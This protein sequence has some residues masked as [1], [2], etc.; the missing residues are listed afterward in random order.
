MELIFVYNAKHGWFHDLTGSIHKVVSPSTYPCDLCALTHG[1]SGMKKRVRQFLGQ[2]RWDTVFYHLND[3]PAELSRLLTECGGAP[4]V[5]VREASGN[6]V[7]LFDAETLSRFA[8]D[9]AFL[10]GLK[11]ALN[12]YQ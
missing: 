12:S 9:K 6:V 1:Y 3:L 2:G 4:A 5:C 8:D 10:D 11:L 7:L